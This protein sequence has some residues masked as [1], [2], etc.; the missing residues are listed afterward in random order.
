LGAGEDASQIS[1]AWVAVPACVVG[2]FVAVAA[3]AI[4]QANQLVDLE[5][6]LP[7][8]ATMTL[9]TSEGKIEFLDLLDRLFKDETSAAAARGVLE[10]K[11]KM[12]ELSSANLERAIERGDGGDELSESLRK[13]LQLGEGPFKF[14]LHSFRDVKTPAV[15]KEFDKQATEK[16]EDVVD[17]LRERCEYGEGFCRNTGKEVYIAFDEKVASGVGEVCRTSR[18][19]GTTV[20]IQGQTALDFKVITLTKPFEPCVEDDHKNK[21]TFIRMNPDDGKNLFKNLFG[22]DREVK[23]VAFVSP[24]GFVPVSVNQG[25]QINSDLGRS[26]AATQQNE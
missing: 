20:Q 11:Y 8:G 21:D 12:Y 1:R 3:M 22:V 23:S 25:D 13:M 5:V 2:A 17:Q 10:K 7:N 9:K 14:N 26:I 15:V 24:H 4:I 6:A 19:I 18:L 16:Y